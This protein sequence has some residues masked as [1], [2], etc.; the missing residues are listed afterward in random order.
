MNS[1]YVHVL[2][3]PGETY[4]VM[5]LMRKRRGRGYF[6]IYAVQSNP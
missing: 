1:S 5:M 6:V 3:S 2:P 4:I